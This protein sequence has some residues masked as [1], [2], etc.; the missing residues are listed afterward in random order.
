MCGITAIYGY[1]DDAPRVDRTELLRIRDH[2]VP[3]GPDGAGEWVHDS[4]RLGFGHRRLS[5]IDLSPSGAQ[6]MADETGQ[7]VIVF[8]GE[9]YN[10]QALR[11]DLESRGH[12]FRSTSD[13]EVLLRLYA[14][15]GVE[16]VHALRGMYAFALWDGAKQ[17]LFLAR[18]PFG[19]KPLYLADD[20]KTIRIASQV[21]ALLA[22]GALTVSPAPAGHVGYFLWGHVPEP[23]TLYR[24]IRALPAGTSLWVNRSG[25]RTPQRFCS[26]TQE[27][28]DAERR[29]PPPRETLQLVRAAV[30]DSVRHHL[31][32]DV[33]VGIFLSAGLDSTTLA[34]LATELSADLRSVTLGFQEYRNTANDEV[35]LAEL[36]AQRYGTAHETV[37]VR[38]EAFHDHYDALLRAMDQPTLDGIN[39]YFVSQAAARTGLKVALSGLGGDE[40]VGGYPSFS[41]IPAIVRRMR[42]IARVPGLG[43]GF[44]L[45]SA[46]LLSR[47]TSPK[48]ASLL[49]YG[50]SYGG[51]YLLRRG[52]FMPWELPAVL[53]G[54]LIREGWRE[55]STIARL[56]ASV[57]GIHSDHLKVSALEM[58]WYMRNQLLRDTDWA[59][60]AHSVEV[61][62]P[63][64]DLTLMRTAASMIAAGRRVNKRCLSATPARALPDAVVNRP[65]T[66]FV[67]PVREWLATESAGGRGLRDWARRVYDAY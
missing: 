60:M 58:T 34:A 5:I 18:D 11:R 53:D 56:D 4:G 67:V 33:P 3:R 38:G 32:S 25:P 66:G 54:E 26:V 23:Y 40:L 20:G 63:L 55:L 41:Q 27:L 39:S 62:V 17:G 29:A 12:V 57:R 9:I 22:G 21:K 65:K 42:P 47:L 15:K 13:T 61:R 7:L 30:L 52:L 1:H 14:D 50:G 48:Y 6:P 37:W 19:I 28:V 46:R 2:M 64:V 16:M 24:E 36:V 43:R 31:V 8:N 51:A 44:R 45:V 49:E 35:P 10:Y 59:S